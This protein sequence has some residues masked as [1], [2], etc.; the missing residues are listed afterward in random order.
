[1][2]TEEKTA[3]EVIGD[4]AGLIWHILEEEGRMSLTKLVKKIDAPRDI[5]MQ[6]V[7]WLAREDKIWI[8]ETGRGR[9]IQLR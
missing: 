1:M 4:T 5:V 9:W 6:G 8:V 3:V 7:G 2:E